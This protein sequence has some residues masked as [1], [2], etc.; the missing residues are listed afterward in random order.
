MAPRLSFDR[1]RSVLRAELASIRRRDPDVDAGEIAGFTLPLL[2][3][4]VGIVAIGLVPLMVVR[5]RSH[6][7]SE[8][9][10][11]IGSFALVLICAAV[12]SWLLS[13]VISGLVVMVL[14]QTRPAASSKLVTRILTE[15]FMRVDDIVS[16]LMLLALVAGLVSLAFGLPAHAADEQANSV[17]DSLLTAQIGVFI[18]ALGVMFV[19]ESIRSAADI[20]D[21]QSLMMAW[22]WA[23]VIGCLSW[24]LATVAGPFEATRMLTLLLQDW[25]PSNID[26]VP[27]AEVIQNLLPPGA[28]WWVAFGPLPV[29][30]GIWAYQA[31]RLDGFTHL[32]GFLAEESPQAS[33]S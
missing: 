24:V 10:P 30:A 27:R 22:P 15:S 26:G 31:W 5:N 12:V 11:I 16:A 25:L 28:R 21:D 33:S 19:A 23:L 7:N 20:V 29:I 3:R 18:V 13:V 1:A 4:V 32:R 2:V 14:Y 6:E 8:L 17:I 9:V